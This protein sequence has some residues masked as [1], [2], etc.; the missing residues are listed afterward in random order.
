MRKFFKGLSI[1]IFAVIATVV[2][3]PISLKVR[4]AESLPPRSNID[5]PSAGQ[6]IGANSTFQVR[7]WA[8]NASGVAKVEVYSD[9]NLVGNA[10]LGYSRPDVNKAYPGYPGGSTSEF[11]ALIGAMPST[12][13]THTIS[14]KVYGKDGSV[15]SN[16]Q[17]YNIFKGAVSNIDDPSAGQQIGASTTFQVRGW[18]LNS[19]GVSKVEVYSDGNLVGNATL[20]YDRP[21]VKL[22]YPNYPENDKAEF[23][24]LIGALPSTTGTHTISIKVYG[25]D[26][27]I[28]SNS[29]N[30][31]IFKG[32]LSNIDNPI[33]GQTIKPNQSLE[34]SGWALNKSGI[35]K[36]VVYCD[37][38][39]IGNAT[40]GY[41][42]PD[43]NA[44]YPGY[45]GGSTSGFKALIGAMPSTPGTHNVSIKVYG[46]DGSVSENI[47]YVKIGTEG[48]SIV[49]YAKKFL[50]TPYVWG[51]TTPIGFDCSG[52]TQYVYAQHGISISRTTY[53]QVNDGI[54]VSQ[55]Q[56]QP[57]DL[58]FTSAHHVGIY[59]GNGQ[60]IHAPET[61]DFVKISN[62]WS[63]YAAR[64]ILK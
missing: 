3:N 32:S 24:A 46:K 54:A 22:A 26:G 15:S 53:T 42:R 50:G 8:L 4:A 5:D 61:G 19:S 43:V 64:R 2:F 10:T 31:N 55:S 49:A 47:A 60:M 56:L 33:S 13:G 7:G 36:V 1:L 9:G 38:N 18:A 28:S 23:R 44:A 16:N 63:F 20:G 6:Q 35:S 17:K 48:D 39:L 21:D 12:T 27:S 11:R 40:L 59:V 25:R 41:S 57:G 51:G 14:I 34:V 58:V 29:Q 52:F 62:I 37:G 30:Y 45:P